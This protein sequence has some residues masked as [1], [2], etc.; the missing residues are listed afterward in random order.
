[1]RVRQALRSKGEAHVWLDLRLRPT[2]IPDYQQDSENEQLL[3][4]SRRSQLQ[5]ERDE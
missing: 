3:P 1:M 4:V 2:Q 5:F